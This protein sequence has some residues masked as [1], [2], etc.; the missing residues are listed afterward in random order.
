MERRS[1]KMKKELSKEELLQEI[2]DKGFKYLQEF[3]N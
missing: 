2:R 3:K 1:K